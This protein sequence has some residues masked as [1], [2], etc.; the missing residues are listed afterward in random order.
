MFRML[1]HVIIFFYE[2]LYSVSHYL[3]A[4]M[5]IWVIQPKNKSHKIP[6]KNLNPISL[7]Q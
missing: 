5:S 4:K 7:N 3:A 6:N 1:N 2:A